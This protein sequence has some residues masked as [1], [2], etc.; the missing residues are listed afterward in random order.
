MT[1]LSEEELSVQP[2][3]SVEVAGLAADGAPA[4]GSP[5][6]PPRAWVARISQSLDFYLGLGCEVQ[7]ADGWVLLG[8]GRTLFV[9]IQITGATQT[10]PRPTHWVRLTPPDCRALRQRLLTDAVSAHPITSPNGTAEWLV[11]DPDLCRVVIA[12]P[13]TEPARRVGP[14]M[15]GSR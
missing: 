13:R 15:A 10:H 12:Q 5:V 14:G 9:L 3:Q 2:I 11:A 1:A 7:C 6:G 4:A 8:C